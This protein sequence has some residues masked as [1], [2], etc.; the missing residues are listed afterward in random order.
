MNITTIEIYKQY[1]QQ[2]FLFLKKMKI[3]WHKTIPQIYFL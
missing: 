1:T 3:I 2:Q